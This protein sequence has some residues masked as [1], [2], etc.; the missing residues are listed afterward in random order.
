MR[1]CILLIEHAY[2]RLIWEKA[3]RQID[4]KGRA[5]RK[6]GPPIGSIEIWMRTYDLPAEDNRVRVTE[7]KQL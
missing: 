5:I 2:L 1:I 6:D 3:M 7:S 4:A